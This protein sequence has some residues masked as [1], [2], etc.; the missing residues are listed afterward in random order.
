MDLTILQFLYGITGSSFIDLVVIFFGKYI[1]YILL[2]GL[3][4]FV[5]K[6]KEWK[7]KVAT[8][9]FLGLNAILAKGVISEIL[10]EITQ[11]ARPFE[12][13]DFI[14]LIN[15]TNFSFPSDHAAFLFA[16][17]LAVYYFNSKWGVWYI[18]LSSLNIIARVMAGIHWPSDV[19]AGVL[20]AFVSF[21]IV[22]L[23][24]EKYLS[25]SDQRG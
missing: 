15:S 18:V 9:C 23:L 17:S 25:I 6:Q 2:L 22:Y 5:L 14:P 3:V 19:L 16:I 13:L 10:K 1:P 24:T 12:S 4:V 20:V 11:R 8:F 7:M 21:G